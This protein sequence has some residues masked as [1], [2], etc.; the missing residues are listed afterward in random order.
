MASIIRITS[1]SREFMRDLTKVE[2]GIVR[3]ASEAVNTVASMAHVQAMRN[4]RSMTLRNQYTEGSLRFLPSKAIRSNGKFR[5]I[6]KINAISGTVSPYLPIQDTGG[7]IRAKRKKRMM[8]TTAGRGGSPRRVIPKKLRLPNLGELGGMGHKKS[9]MGFFV[10]PSGV[11]YRK[12]RGSK[13]KRALPGQPKPRRPLV[14]VYTA[15]QTTQIVKSRKWHA[16][17]MKRMGTWDNLA[18]AFRQAAERILKS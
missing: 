8:V 12:G 3:A 7:T 4:L 1:N 2:G 15:G 13:K 11:Y 6:E 5:D 17:A 10:L 9:S 16:D 14:M 18:T